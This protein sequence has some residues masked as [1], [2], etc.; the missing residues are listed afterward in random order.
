MMISK[1]TI[2]LTIMVDQYAVLVIASK[3]PKRIWYKFVVLLIRL[4]IMT[5][6][7]KNAVKL[8]PIAASCFVLLL[9]EINPINRLANIPV[10]KAPTNIGMLKRNESATPGNTAW[11]IASPM[12]DNPLNT[13]R[14]P[15]VPHTMPTHMEM[16]KAR[17]KN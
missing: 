17:F 7:A 2:T 12:S 16:I 5:P 6:T 15:T 13:I 9:S 14:L 8:I 1:R 4:I 3:L 10:T 11:L